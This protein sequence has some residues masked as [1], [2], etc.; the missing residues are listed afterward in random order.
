MRNARV[1]ALPRRR[2]QPRKPIS[3]QKPLRA[4]LGYVKELPADARAC[5]IAAVLARLR[6]DVALLGIT[7][8]AGR[9][10]MTGPCVSPRNTTSRHREKMVGE[11][12]ASRVARGKRL[13]DCTIDALQPQP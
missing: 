9:W 10:A 1:G 4:E 5:E 7:E 13:E 8:P 3:D 2:R 12:A 6:E 11:G